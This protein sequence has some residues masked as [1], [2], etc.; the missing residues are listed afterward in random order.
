VLILFQRPIAAVLTSLA[1]IAVAVPA[2]RTAVRMVA[3]S[4]RAPA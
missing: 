3:L 2:A 1:L 4:R